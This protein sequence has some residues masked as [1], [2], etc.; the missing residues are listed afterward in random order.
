MNYSRLLE[1]CP[2][3]CDRKMV[4]NE[5]GKSMAH[6]RAKAYTRDPYGYETRA[7]DGGYSLEGDYPDGRK[8]G[9]NPSPSGSIYT[10]HGLAGI[11]VK[12]TK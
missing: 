8:D 11:S 6:R 3:P 7:S 2:S 5:G 12:V 9:D 4:T 10:S 1:K